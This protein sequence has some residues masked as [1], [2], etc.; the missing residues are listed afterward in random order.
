M[1]FCLLFIDEK[2]RIRRIKFLSSSKLSSHGSSMKNSIG[3]RHR[4]QISVTGSSC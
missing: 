2:K 4:N 1:L 3:L